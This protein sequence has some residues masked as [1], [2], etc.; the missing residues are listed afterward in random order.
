LLA[1]FILCAPSTAR[2]GAGTC[3]GTA[4][5]ASVSRAAFA[6][7]SAGESRSPLCFHV[8]VDKAEVEEG[9]V[10]FQVRRLIASGFLLFLRDFFIQVVFKNLPPWICLGII[11]ELCELFLVVR[12]GLH[13]AVA[14]EHLLELVKRF[15]AE[16]L[17]LVGKD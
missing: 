13:S 9:K 17:P 7:E 5:S 2:T 16:L 1:A 4:A 3:A 10:R 8:R 15:I 11:V 14:A 12:F 6:Y